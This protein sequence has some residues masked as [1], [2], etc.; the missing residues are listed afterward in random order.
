[1]RPLLT[2]IV[3]GGSLLMLV[4]ALAAAGDRPKG[5]PPKVELPPKELPDPVEPDTTKNA[6]KRAKVCKALLA[7]IHKLAKNKNELRLDTYHIDMYAENPELTYICLRFATGAV[8]P[9]GSGRSSVDGGSFYLYDTAKDK[10]LGATPKFNTLRN[11]YNG[12]S[13]DEVKG[14][15]G[16]KHGVFIVWYYGAMDG[17][18][19]PLNPEAIRKE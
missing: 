7:N 1:M 14:E 16:K 8:F 2:T 17:T 3:L 15:D 19:D 11:H 12:L 10:L 9:D 18:I 5:L 6:A 13:Y 4:Y